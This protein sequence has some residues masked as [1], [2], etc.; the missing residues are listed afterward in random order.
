MENSSKKEPLRRG[1]E[2]AYKLYPHSCLSSIYALRMLRGTQQRARAGKLNNRTENLA[3]RH[4]RRDRVDFEFRQFVRM[5]FFKGRQRNPYLYRIIYNIID[6]NLP[7]KNP[8]SLNGFIGN[9]IR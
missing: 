9:S 5:T 6:I 7:G 1:Y 4:Y 2:F 3:A 8:G